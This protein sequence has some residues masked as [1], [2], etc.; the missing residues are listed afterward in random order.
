MAWDRRT[1][2]RYARARGEA[3]EK[4]GQGEFVLLEIRLPA[5]VAERILKDPWEA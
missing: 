5:E 2:S 4:R 1:A 3:G